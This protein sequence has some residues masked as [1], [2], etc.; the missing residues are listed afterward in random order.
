[1]KT[2]ANDGVLTLYPEGHVDSSN[3]KQF[4]QE[5]MEAMDASS[6]TSVVLDAR[7]LNYISSAGLRVLMKVMRRVGSTVRVINTNA[8]V[9]EVFEITGFSELMDVSMA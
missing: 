7:E 3:A 6:A 1:M 4:D 8:N 2:T 5:V 9:Y